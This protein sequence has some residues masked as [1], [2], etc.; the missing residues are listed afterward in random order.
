MTSEDDGLK[1]RITSYICTYPEKTGLHTATG[2]LWSWPRT[3][4]QFAVQKRTCTI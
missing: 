1:R 2:L 4:I 3:A